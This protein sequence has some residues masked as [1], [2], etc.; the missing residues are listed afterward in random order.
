MI[1]F[2]SILTTGALLLCSSAAFAQYAGSIIQPASNTVIAPGESFPFQYDIVAD[3]SVSSYN[4]NVYL[5]TEPPTTFTP[6][7]SF[8]NGYFYGRYDQANY[9]GV[10]YA[11]HPAPSNFTMPD[12]SKNPGGF[13]S[14]ASASN[15][16]VYLTVIEEYATGNGV[17][18]FRMNLALTPLIY[19]GTTV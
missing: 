4:F 19:N 15:S 3:Y 16:T 8:A 13:G 7:G 12:F 17:L 9:P 18:G 2:R 10:P 14:G 1:A 5:F 11:T 6:S